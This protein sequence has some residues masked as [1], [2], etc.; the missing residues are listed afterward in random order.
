[1]TPPI[2]AVTFDLGGVLID[3]N[4][5]YLYRKLFDG[6]E[7]AME[8]FLTNVTN[9]EWN[10]KMDAG[11]PFSQGVA[12]LAAAHPDQADLIRAYHARW[13]EMLGDAFHDTLAIVRE[14]RAAGL[15]TYALSNWSSETFA[16]TRRHFAWLADFDGV[17]ISG[18]VKL[19]KPDPA[20]FREFLRRFAL[21]PAAT[22][23]VD[24]WDLNVASANAV[25][26]RAIQFVGADALR[27]ELRSMGLPLAESAT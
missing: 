9:L 17:L 24:D 27:A 14:V 10:A 3:W 20:I 11:R 6:D 1:M 21:D 26:M 23:Y 19:A 7:A 22:V 4:P 18:D 25:G 2:T 5:R 8:H 12:D 15:R 16:T 13:E